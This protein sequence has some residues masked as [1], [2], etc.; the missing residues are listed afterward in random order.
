MMAIP[1]V[2]L[3]FKG[4]KAKFDSALLFNF[5]FSSFN[6]NAIPTVIF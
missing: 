1:S 6:I 5:L 3:V 2:T 4:C